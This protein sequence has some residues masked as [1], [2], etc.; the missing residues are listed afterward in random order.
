MQTN[1][2]EQTLLSVACAENQAEISITRQTNPIEK[3]VV[4]ETFAEKPLEFCTQS[5][6]A[7]NGPVVSPPVLNELDI[8]PVASAGEETPQSPKLQAGA[9]WRNRV[10]TQHTLVA[11][12]PRHLT[13]AIRG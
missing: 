1:P 4:S 11:S 9:G 12:Q 10:A 8:V 6:I 2:T 13:K 3:D 5:Q 7:P